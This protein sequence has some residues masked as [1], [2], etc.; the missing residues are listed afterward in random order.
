MLTYLTITVY[1]ACNRIR[2]KNQSS[3][4]ISE[5]QLCELVKWSLLWCTENM[6]FLLLPRKSICWVWCLRSACL[7]LKKTINL[8]LVATVR[9]TLFKTIATGERDEA[10]LGVQWG[11][12]DFTVEKRGERVC[13]WSTAK[14]THQATGVLAKLT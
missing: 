9:K 14:G 4:I 1:T 10:W 7:D 11:S 13:G 3:L 8:A 2:K 6:Y 12:W 5:T